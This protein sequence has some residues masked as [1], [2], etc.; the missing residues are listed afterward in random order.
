MSLAHAIVQEARWPGMDEPTVFHGVESFGA[1]S[2]V[3]T[4]KIL[5]LPTDPPVLVGIVD[6]PDR[7]QAFLPHLDDMIL[8]G[9]VPLEEVIVVWY[10]STR[11]HHVSTAELRQS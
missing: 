5:A 6:R 4:A 10:H 11:S 2:R 7:I 1:N 3:H 9:L 8:D